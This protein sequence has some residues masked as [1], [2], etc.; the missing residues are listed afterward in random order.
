[1]TKAQVVELVKQNLNIDNS[2]RDLTISDFVILFC[3]Y[4]NREDVPENAEPFIRKKVKSIIDYEI[5]L[6]N[7]ENDAVSSGAV[8]SITEGDTSILYEVT[9]DMTKAGIYGLT[10][11]DKAYLN[12]FRKVRNYA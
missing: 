10:K 6:A 11:L 1:M 4:C 2:V 7:E 3:E 9:E 5:G 12:R 8:K